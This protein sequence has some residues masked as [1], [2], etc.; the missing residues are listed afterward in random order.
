MLGLEAPVWHRYYGLC[1]KGAEGARMQREIKQQ[2][3]REIARVR[4]HVFFD[5]LKR[6]SKGPSLPAHWIPFPPSHWR[7]MNVFLVLPTADSSNHMQSKNDKHCQE[8]MFVRCVSMLWADEKMR[9]VHRFFH[10]IFVWP[11]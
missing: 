10:H 7:W 1:K 8:G 2:T 9:G 6:Q 4:A 11:L 3:C 5:E